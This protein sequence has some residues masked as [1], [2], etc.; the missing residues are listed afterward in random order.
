[1]SGTILVVDDEQLVRWSLR[2][3]L[4]AQGYAVVDAESGR[5]ARRAF[6]E[7]VDVVLQ[8]VCLPDSQGIDLLRAFR[9]ADPSPPVILMTAHSTVEAAVSAM[10][11]GAF[12]YLRKPFDLEEVASL[13]HTALE[14]SNLAR[15]ARR[16]RRSAAAA[17]LGRII[18]ESS[19]M[20]RVK[21]LIARVAAS[22]LST[23]LV[24]GESGTGKDLVA[25][26]I[27]DMSQRASGPF[28]NVTCSALTETLLESE[29]FGH[30]RG[31]FT[32]ART[33][34]RGL[35]EQ[36]DGGTVFLDEISE[37]SPSFQAK[38]LRFLEAKAFRRVG[39]TREIRPDVRVIA[40]T[41]RDLEKS[42]GEGEFRAD[43]YYRLAVL[44][45]ELPPLRDREDD[46]AL[47]AAALVGT[48]NGSLN[49][50]IVGISSAALDLLRSHSWPGNVRE[51]RN[52]IERAM[53]FADRD[54]LLAAHF[55]TVAPAQP[56]R[57]DFRLPAAGVDFT[58]L[59]RSLVAQ[60]L[61]ASRGNQTR[62]AALLGMNRDQIRYRI[63]KFGLKHRYDSPPLASTNEGVRRPGHD[64]R[65][66][67]CAPAEDPRQRL[68]SL[69][70]RAVLAKRARP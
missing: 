44:R 15:D 9:L 56:A 7:G 38:L 26:A 24:A 48:L 69:R 70:Q 36:A 60:A 23:V 21:D 17:A 13:V 8:D 64:R 55:A 51:L 30:E 40:A 5:E 52:A 19:E 39:G 22:S 58:E 53:L 43:L 32:D 11:E 28:I 6:D 46:I 1:M 45:I 37:T 49:K 65:S 34:K 16:L 42:V 54:M 20:R 66:Y 29:L 3:H 12:H 50:G 2:R 47:L 62:A 41:N 31:A 27:H 4:E 68:R 35:L 33:Q 14:R 59:E 25:H 18:G 57:A 67:S 61:D 63:H 10:Q